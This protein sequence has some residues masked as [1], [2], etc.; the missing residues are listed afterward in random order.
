MDLWSNFWSNLWTGITSV[1]NFFISFPPGVASILLL[2]ILGL[3][4]IGAI[5]T[6]VRRRSFDPFCWP[7]VIYALSSFFAWLNTLTSDPTF[8]QWTAGL[9]SFTALIS[10]LWV[11]FVTIRAIFNVK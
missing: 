6:K 11:L 7:I 3:V 5:A 1:V 2:V 4:V 9:F 8:S 10:F